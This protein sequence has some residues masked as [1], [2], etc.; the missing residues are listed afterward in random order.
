VRID[1]V[2]PGRD[3]VH[4]AVVLQFDRVANVGKL[5]VLKDHKVVLG[6]ELAQLLRHLGRKVLQN[7]NVRLM[8]SSVN[9]KHKRRVRT[10]LEHA[11]VRPAHVDNVQEL[12][13]GSHV[14]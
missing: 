11:D 5:A 1:N 6:R 2:R 7:V 12:L 13:R 9:S 8:I 10:C 14:S 3:L 4:T